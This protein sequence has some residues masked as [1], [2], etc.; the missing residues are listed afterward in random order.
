MACR[1]SEGKSAANGCATDGR[2]GGPADVSYSGVCMTVGM[3]SATIQPQ[4]LGR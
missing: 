1:A 2:A 4:A 3:G